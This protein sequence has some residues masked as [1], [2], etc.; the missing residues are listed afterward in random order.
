MIYDL[1]NK[2]QELE[3]NVLKLVGHENEGFGL[4]WHPSQ[5]GIILSGS[6]DK[7]IFM[8]DLFQGS[9]NANWQATDGVEDV[10][11]SFLDPHIFG[12]AQQ[13]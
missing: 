9:Q 6:D 2:E 4:D 7:Q 10:K 11:W 3:Q 5:P 13:D 8:F 12:S 1:R